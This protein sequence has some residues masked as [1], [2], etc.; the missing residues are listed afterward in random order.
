MNLTYKN[1]IDNLPLMSAE[2]GFT[3]SELLVSMTLFSVVGLGLASFSNSVLRT[4]SIESRATSATEELR[5]AVSLL[6]SE[7]R[8]SQSLSPYLVGDL[9]SVVT[10]SGAFSV[11]SSAVKFIVVEDDSSATTSGLQPYYVGYSYDAS[12]ETLYRGEVAASSI[13]ACSIPSTDPT[14]AGVR[15]ILAESVIPVDG[16]GDGSIDP[17]FEFT[18]SVLRVNLGV[19]I[20]GAGGTKIEQAI[21]A[22]IAIRME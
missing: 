12:T 1:V 14:S 7:L 11:S 2:Q 6:S 8:M 13:T 18:G 21:P 17:V 16:N 4:V 10:C 20:D 19:R 5:N 9:S 22:Q 15:Q 3:I